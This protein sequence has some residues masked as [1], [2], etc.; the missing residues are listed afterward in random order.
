M[1]LNYTTTVE[2]NILK[3][4]AWDADTETDDEVTFNIRLN[5]ERLKIF[6]D[7]LEN[8]QLDHGIFEIQYYQGCL[9]FSIGSLG[10]DGHITFEISNY[11][12]E[13]LRLAKMVVDL[14]VPE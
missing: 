10:R 3:I 2:N 6:T 12:D 14:Y 13:V 9:S 4:R 1:L 8:P 7:I 5:N 11:D